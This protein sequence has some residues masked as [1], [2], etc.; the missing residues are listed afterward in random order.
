MIQMH[1]VLGSPPQIPHNVYGPP[2]Q[3]F[4]KP[5]FGLPIKSP[6][7]FRPQQIYGVPSA[8]IRQPLPAYGPPS[9]PQIK[10]PI[11]GA[12]CDGWKPIFG[13]SVG[14]QQI[15]AH[16]SAEV[17][18]NV[19]P[20]NT[21]LPPSSNSIQTVAD[22]HLQV[23]PLPTNLQLPAV[24]P[25]NFNHHDLGTHLGNSLSSGLGLTNINVIKSEGIEV[26]STT[27]LFSNLSSLHHQSIP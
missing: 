5:I 13:P 20:E 6:V 9:L 10:N 27:K 8:P 23:Q 17:I 21:Y 24:G 1:F 3:S 18:Q 12:G 14:T 25:S 4:S 16:N 7:S 11:H 26:C 2:K 15:V 22:A 19:A